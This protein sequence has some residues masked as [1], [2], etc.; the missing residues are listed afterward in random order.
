MIAACFDVDRTLLPGTSMEK[1]FIIW[2][3]RHGHL[4]LGDALRA[5]LDLS[6]R[7]DESRRRGYM[8]YHGYLERRRVDDVAKWA[9]TCFAS[10]IAPRVSRKGLERLAEHR[11]AGHLTILLSGSIQPLVDRMGK[12]VGADVAI[13][14][15]LESRDGHFT[16]RLLGEHVAHAQKAVAVAEL[17]ERYDLDLSA[18][19]CYADHRSDLPMLERFGRP[20][21]TNPDRSLARIARERGWEIVEFG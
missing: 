6:K 8:Q 3:L 16:G 14:T 2:L 7:L 20:V 13:G 21:P 9:D 12:H 17:A 18:S 15:V 1:I 4:G 11:A 5:A 10:L 19:Y